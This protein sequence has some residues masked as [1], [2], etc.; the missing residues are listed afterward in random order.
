MCP[1]P[2]EFPFLTLLRQNMVQPR[3]P[4]P[5]PEHVHRLQNSAKALKVGSKA[6]KL[7]Y[8]EISKK[9]VYPFSLIHI[10]FH[11][12]T[13]KLLKK[14]Y[15]SFEKVNP[16]LPKLLN[17]A[18]P[19]HMMRNHAKYNFIQQKKSRTTYVVT[20]LGINDLFAAVSLSSFA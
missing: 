3:S 15:F 11:L 16:I 10:I 19:A 13:A 12:K 17:I 6:Q 1:M 14:V 7:L 4:T 2:S 8:K 20:T 9:K 18:I 5:H